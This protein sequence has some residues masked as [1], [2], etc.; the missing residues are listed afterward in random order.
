MKTERIA[1][2]QVLARRPRVAAQAGQP[3]RLLQRGDL[4]GDRDAEPPLCGTRG[5]ARRQIRAGVFALPR[6]LVELRRRHAA[7]IAV[8]P[9][10]LLEAV[11]ASARPAHPSGPPSPAS[12]WPAHG[13]G[14]A[15]VW[16]PPVTTTTRPGSVGDGG[17][18]RGLARAVAVGREHRGRVVAAGQGAVGEHIAEELGGLARGRRRPR[19]DGPRGRP[20]RGR[21][22]DGRSPARA[23]L[24]DRCRS[25]KQADGLRRPR[26]VAPGLAPSPG[27]VR[28]MNRAG[29]PTSAA[30]RIATS[31]GE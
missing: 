2:E 24:C 20:G 25:S 30:A 13:P 15:T 29:R 9:V 1:V 31:S 19:R 27:S 8:E 16:N 12:A 26:L 4:V 17:G 11:R 7:G 21:R 14:K 6:P 23:A 5:P 18:H 22:R 3:P 28:S 10:E